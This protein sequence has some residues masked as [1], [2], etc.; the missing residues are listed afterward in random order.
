MI[1]M[2]IIVTFVKKSMTQS[3]GSITVKIAL[4]L[5]IPIV[6]L[7][8]T[9]IFGLEILTHLIVIH[10]HL[11]SL[12]KLKTALN[13][14]S[15]V[16]LAKSLSYSVSNVISTSTINVCGVRKSGF[17]FCIYIFFFWVKLFKKKKILLSLMCYYSSK[18]WVLPTFYN[19][20]LRL[21][22][23]ISVCIKTSHLCILFLIL[24]TK[25][26]LLRK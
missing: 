2:N 24:L 12:R 19:I 23:S 9:Q 4:I 13:V 5:L 22:V 14:T 8:N 10:T 20:K 1:L 15:V 3:V 16:I 21:L 7:G 18:K 26:T 11:L 17:N 25:I 6:F